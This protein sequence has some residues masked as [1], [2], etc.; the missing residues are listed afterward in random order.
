MYP[1][2]APCYVDYDNDGKAEF[3][4]SNN[5]VIRTKELTRHFGSVVAVQNLTLTVHSGEVFGFLG[6][7][8][9][10][11]TTTVRLLNGIL[12][13]T[14]GTVEVLGL[15]PIADGPALRLQTGVLTETPSLD[16]R[17]TAGE[18]LTTYGRLYN[19]SKD[20]LNK[21]VTELLEQFGLLERK[22]E[23][24]GGFSKGMR[25]RLALARTLLHDPKVIF[26]DE[27]TAGLDPI[28]RRA[29]H[30][31]IAELSS[32]DGR[33]IFLCTHDL[34]E[35]QQLCNR[36][37]VMEHGNLVALGTPE[38]LA[39][40]LQKGVRL[41]IELDARPDLS[42]LGSQTVKIGTASPEPAL[43]WDEE[44][45]TARAWLPTRSSIPSLINTLVT[46][47]ARIYGVRR[48]EPSLEDVYFALHEDR[49]GDP[50]L[51]G[52]A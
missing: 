29:V 13:A 10:G 47:G 6:H 43:E 5:I 51:G 11:K 39:H 18:T 28:G 25:Q 48:Q 22:T 3:V 45:H 27:P 30:N 52:K 20:R 15:N 7:N 16:D 24:V 23:L 33:T 44:T 49:D 8:G 40:S 19:V 31:L 32:N 17:L 38:E 35:A 46:S 42:W 12:G 21:R 14:A 26:L 1:L 4:K 36:V 41:E 9:A 50:L 34:A 37:G 2:Q